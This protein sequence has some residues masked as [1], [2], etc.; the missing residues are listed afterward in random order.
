MDPETKQLLKESLELSKENNHML[1][2]MVRSQ[3]WTNVY[4]VVYWGIIIFSSVGAY[5]FIQPYLSNLVNVYTGGVSGLG[6]I[7]DMSK[8][9]NLDAN[10]QQLQDLIDA[11]KK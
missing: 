3:R 10:K 6:N 1:K 11:F 4:R 5:Y 8:N 9:L 7:S 2:K